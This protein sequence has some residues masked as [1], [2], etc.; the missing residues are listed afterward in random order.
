MR[1][2]FLLAAC[3]TLLCLLFPLLAN[4]E[5]LGFKR[6]RSTFALGIDVFDAML[7]EFGDASDIGMS[8]FAETTLQFGGYYGIHF[9]FGSAR[10]FTKKNFL[11]FDEGY[12]FVYFVA[13]PRFNLAPFRKRMLIFYLQPEIELQVLISNTLVKITGNQSTT[14]AA[15][16]SLGVQYVLGILSI[17]G[18]ASCR[19][20]WDL[21]SLFVGGSISIGLSNVIK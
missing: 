4:A 9:R 10:A 14:G 8:I 6:P 5:P 16:G 13:A 1:N 11:P 12:Q 17:S 20:N 7:G 3:L 18:Q 19:Y 2:T 21:Q 15:G